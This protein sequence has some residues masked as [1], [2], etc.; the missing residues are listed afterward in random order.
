MSE[1]KTRNSIISKKLK[2]LFFFQFKKNLEMWKSIWV[3]LEFLRTQKKIIQLKKKAW[4][5]LEFTGISHKKSIF[6]SILKKILKKKS[7]LTPE[8][9]RIFETIGKINK[10]GYPTSDTFSGSYWRRRV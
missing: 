7:E 2:K 1:K 5:K 9:S 10:A 3:E 8:S 4:K 6:L